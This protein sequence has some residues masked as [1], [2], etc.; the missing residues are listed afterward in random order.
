MMRERGGLTRNAS[1]TT[2]DGAPGPD[3]EPMSKKTPM[4]SLELILLY[5]K[6]A[7]LIVQLLPPNDSS[8][9][10][11]VEHAVRQYVSIYVMRSSM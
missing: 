10:T 9:V 8:T 3:D 7:P 6:S 11:D 2:H 4:H 1:P 5:S